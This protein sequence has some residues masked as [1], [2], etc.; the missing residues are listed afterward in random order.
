MCFNNTYL[1]K[2]Q[3]VFDFMPK[4]QDYC[5]Y[6]SFSFIAFELCLLNLSEKPFLFFPPC[7][8]A[9]MIH[10]CFVFYD[11]KLQQNKT[12]IKSFSLKTRMLMYYHYCLV[13]MLRLTMLLLFL[14]NR[15]SNM[16]YSRKA[17][18][19][20]HIWCLVIDLLI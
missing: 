5:S 7:W 3:Q 16:W 15:Q 14:F 18:F 19:L 9:I 8:F 11:N 4:R 13:F 12:A 2:S 20:A 17:S 10:I 6:K 1:I